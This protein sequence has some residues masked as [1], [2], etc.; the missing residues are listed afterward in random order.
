MNK[1]LK[2]TIDWFKK[3]TKKEG[4]SSYNACYDS[5]LNYLDKES[6]KNWDEKSLPEIFEN[7][8]ETD[9]EFATKYYCE[10]SNKTKTYESIHRFLVA[11]DYFYD[12]CLR[13]RGIKCEILE[14]KCHKKNIINIIIGM[15]DDIFDSEV[16]KPLDSEDIKKV[17]SYID[18]YIEKIK[19][20][21]FYQLE[22][23]IIFHMLVKYGFKNNRIYD[24]KMNDFCREKKTLHIVCENNEDIDLLLDNNIYNNILKLNKIHKYKDRQFLFTDTCGQKL[25]SGTIFSQALKNYIKKKGINNFKPTTVGLYGVTCLMNKNLSIGEITALTGY[26]VTKL[27]EVSNYILSKKDLSQLI[28]SKVY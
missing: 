27:E 18:E 26:E 28:N 7:L 9:I 10:S 20:N 17:S 22:Q 23:K 11:M 25:D 19:T 12:K 8:K 1:E 2:M 13:N 16:Y 15:V 21:A 6:P 5:F 3:I 14:S 4:R 24:F